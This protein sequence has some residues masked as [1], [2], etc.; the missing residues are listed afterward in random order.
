MNWLYQRT[1]NFSCLQSFFIKP[2]KRPFCVKWPR[3][4]CRIRLISRCPSPANPVFDRQRSSVQPCCVHTDHATLLPFPL[5]PV[6][7]RKVTPLDAGRKQKGNLRFNYDD[8]V[9]NYHFRVG[10]SR[11]GN[12]GKLIFIRS[13]A[14]IIN[15]Q[16]PPLPLQ[17]SPK[18]K[19]SEDAMNN[20]ENGKGNEDDRKIFAGGL[21]QVGCPIYLSNLNR[22]SK[23]H[24]TFHVV[25]RQGWVVFKPTAQHMVM[26]VRF[27]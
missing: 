17:T 6:E 7:E 19:M 27:T 12:R 18:N 25:S 22:N 24:R 9:P 4:V 10:L 15:F 20:A 3:L 13:H 11:P 2:E 23:V 5:L 14:S 8:L 1:Q 21:P 26:S 16:P